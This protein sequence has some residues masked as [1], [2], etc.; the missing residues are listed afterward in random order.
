[1]RRLFIVLVLLIV[2]VLG[3]GYCREWLKV[4]TSSDSKTININVVVDKEKM[5]EDEEKAKEKLRQVGGQIRDKAGSLTDKTK[6]DGEEKAPAD[7]PAGS[8]EKNNHN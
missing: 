8:E 1:M 6:K 3:L 5:Q 4:T 2:G 7:R